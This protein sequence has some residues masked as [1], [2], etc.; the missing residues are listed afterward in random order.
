M[1]LTSFI[2]STYYM[3]IY[4]MILIF[5]ASSQC[6]KVCMTVQ[7]TKFVL[8]STS[9]VLSLIFFVKMQRRYLSKLHVA[10]RAELRYQ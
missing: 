2:A 1:H 6:N 3:A 9:A 5:L 4:N 10:D 7:V 8:G